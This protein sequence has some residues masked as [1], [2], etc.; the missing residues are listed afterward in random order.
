MRRVLGLLATAALTLTACGPGGTSSAPVPEEPSPTMPATGPW[1]DA[2]TITVA[3]L[4]ACPLGDSLD[5]GV[6][7]AGVNACTKGTLGGIVTAGSTQKCNLT[8]GGDGTMTFVSPAL[9]QAITLAPGTAVFY[10]HTRDNGLS[11]LTYTLEN[12]RYAPSGRVSIGFAFHGQMTSE[13][14]PNI[15]IS[16]R[17]DTQTATCYTRIK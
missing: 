15:Y 9:S 13:A 14:T 4:Q 2:S 3:Q 16:V 1:G 8:L 7:P 11:T 17:A 5:N 6:I 12:N 10:G